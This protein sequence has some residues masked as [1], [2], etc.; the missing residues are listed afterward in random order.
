MG[1]GSSHSSGGYGQQPAYNTKPAK[2][3][4]LSG[5]A[6]L[7]LGGRCSV[8]CSVSQSGPHAVSSSLAGAGLL[9]G[10]VLADGIE[11]IYDD[12]Y[13]NGFDNGYDD[14]GGFDDF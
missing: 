7:A 2:Q 6:G 8:F 12:G 9:G 3:G 13:D 14:G 5:G 10:L 4:G 1:G 11:H